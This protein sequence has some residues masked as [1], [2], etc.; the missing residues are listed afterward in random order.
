MSF[1]APTIQICGEL[2]KKK[3]K[4]IEY[5]LLEGTPKN[6]AVNKPKM[7]PSTYDF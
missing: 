1:L 3:R 5:H 4:M 7:K 6:P 2:F